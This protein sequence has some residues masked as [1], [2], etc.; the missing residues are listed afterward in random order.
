MSSL[1][2]IDAKGSRERAMIARFF[3]LPAS[4]VVLGVTAFF[5]LSPAV[6]LH[7]TLCAFFV[8]ELE[9]QSNFCVLEGALGRSNMHGE[10]V[11]CQRPTLSRIASAG[12]VLACH[13]TATVLCKAVCDATGCAFQVWDYAIPGRPIFTGQFFC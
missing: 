13:V 11:S 9:A 12:L 4:F 1:H 8:T 7:F 10:V 5:G 3:L 6:L 2:N